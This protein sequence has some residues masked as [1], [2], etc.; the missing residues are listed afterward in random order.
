MSMYLI[1]GYVVLGVSA[2]VWAFVGS[3][4][5]R[6]ILSDIRVRRERRERIEDSRAPANGGLFVQPVQQ[7][8]APE[9]G[10][11]FAHKDEGNPYNWEPRWFK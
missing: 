6:M 1:I 8:G 3:I 5:V 4:F 7:S 9:S 2:L 11:L 10:H